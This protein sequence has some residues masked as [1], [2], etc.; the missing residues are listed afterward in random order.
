MAEMWRRL[1]EHA[2]AHHDFDSKAVL[3]GTAAGLQAVVLGVTDEP[4]S[5][6]LAEL[7]KE[8]DETPAAE[9]AAT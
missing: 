2:E 4:L 6:R 5:N 9:S 1:A 8:L 7:L 3:T